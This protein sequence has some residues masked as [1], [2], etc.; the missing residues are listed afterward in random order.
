MALKRR[1]LEILP[2]WLVTGE[3]KLKSKFLNYCERH[4]DL[5]DY[6]EFRA[7]V[8]KLRS[9]WQAWPDRLRDGPISDGNFDPQVRDYHMVAGWLIERQVS[10]VAARSR[11]RGGGLYLDLPVG[12]HVSSFDVWRNQHL[13]AQGMSVGAPP[14]QLFSGG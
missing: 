10:Q 3:S 2:R 12:V 14:D 6:A 9:P 11:S 5:R 7:V 1:F 13:Y 8:E 4:K